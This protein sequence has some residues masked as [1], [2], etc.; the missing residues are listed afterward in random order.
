MQQLQRR[1]VGERFEERL[2]VA[3]RDGVDQ[4]DAPLRR[5]LNETDALLVD[6]EAIRLRVYRDAIC[7]SKSFGGVPY[8][9]RVIDEDDV[10]VRGVAYGCPRFRPILALS[11]AK[12]S[13]HSSRASARVLA[14]SSIKKRIRV[15]IRALV[16][17]H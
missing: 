2:E 13:R 17:G 12:S 11:L 14:S 6:V 16:T 9:A 5:D 4:E 7:T 8:S 3:D 15:R 1:R 10:V